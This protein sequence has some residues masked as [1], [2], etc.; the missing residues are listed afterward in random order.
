MVLGVYSIQPLIECYKTL[1]SR[2]DLVFDIEISE[3]WTRYY[4][5]MVLTLQQ[6]SIFLAAG[7][8]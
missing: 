7:T 5:V 2:E 4:Q 1:K 6:C 8:A 3:T